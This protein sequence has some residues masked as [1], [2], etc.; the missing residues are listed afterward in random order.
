MIPK[1]KQFFFFFTII[2]E[3]SNNTRIDTRRRVNF[4]KKF[5]VVESPNVINVSNVDGSDFRVS[6]AQILGAY[7]FLYT[8]ICTYIHR[9]ASRAGTP[10]DFK[11]AYH[12]VCLTK[13]EINCITCKYRRAT[14]ARRP[15]A[16]T[17]CQNRQFRFFLPKRNQSINKSPPI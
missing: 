6:I 4:S 15:L 10:D 13:K 7:V 17:T 11:R 9:V 2:I 12:R 16:K 8:L 3:R 14:L 1:T 5:I